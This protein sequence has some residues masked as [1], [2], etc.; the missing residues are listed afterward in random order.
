MRGLRGEALLD[1]LQARDRR[2]HSRSDGGR[3]GSPRRQS[4]DCRTTPRC[5]RRSRRRTASSATTTA[6]TA[7]RTRADWPSIRRGR[8]RCGNS[9]DT[10]ADAP[11]PAAPAWPIR[12]CPGCC[13]R[14]LT[15]GRAPCPATARRRRR[16]RG[17]PNRSRPARGALDAE[18]IDELLEIV[19]ERRL[20]ARARCVGREEARRTVAAQIGHDRAASGCHQRRNHYVVGARVVREPVHEQDRNAVS[21]SPLCLVGD[22]QH[23]GADAVENGRHVML[24]RSRLGSCRRAPALRA[25]ANSPRWCAPC[26][27]GGA[28]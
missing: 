26:G 9:I 22:L 28:P 1:R 4:R 14:W 2:A 18:R 13:S 8:A 3:T 16:R 19:A 11:A 24:R 5:A 6:T 17:R 23:A 7:C 10:R 21:G 20:L 25:R 12:R 27:R 15:P